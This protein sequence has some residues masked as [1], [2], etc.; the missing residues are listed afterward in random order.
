MKHHR[1]FG[2]VSVHRALQLLKHVIKAISSYESFITNAIKSVYFDILIEVVLD[3]KYAQAL[4]IE[5]FKE[6]FGHIK[7]SIPVAIPGSTG[8]F[9]AVRPKVLRAFCKALVCDVTD[10][11]FFLQVFEFCSSLLREIMDAGEEGK[12]SGAVFDAL[13]YLIDNHGVNHYKIIM[14]NIK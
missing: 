1:Q 10:D 7:E 6:L 12:Y 11:V 3:L 5:S 4:S 8:H 13:A 14:E 9:N 2:D